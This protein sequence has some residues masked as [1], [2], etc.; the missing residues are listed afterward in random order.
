M[1][2]SEEIAKSSL[3]WIDVEATSLDFSTN[4]LIQV[5]AIVTNNNLEILGDG[6]E[7]VI[8]L[9]DTQLDKMSEWCKDTFSKNGL[10]SRSKNSSINL[11]EAEQI[12]LN[13]LKKH[14]EYQTSP[15]CGNSIFLDRLML[16]NHMPLVY[17]FL[18][19]RSI[20]LSTLSEL[21][22]RYYPDVPKITK[23]EDH[24]AFTDIKDSIKQL[25][26]FRETILK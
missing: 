25:K 26:Y 21:K 19:Y 1:K 23:S 2:K 20:D 8:H 15:L 24:D 14:C 18:H 10:T 12:I 7:V 6:A 3:I 13:Y 16:M 4:R 17:D 11:K 22:H 9:S 5:A